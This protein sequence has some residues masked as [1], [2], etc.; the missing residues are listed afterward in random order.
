MFLILFMT[1]NGRWYL[2]FCNA[3]TSLG[4][5]TKVSKTAASDN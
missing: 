2:W 4:S 3:S 1:H 5:V